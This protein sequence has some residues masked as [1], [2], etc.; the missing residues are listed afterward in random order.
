[1]ILELT[2]NT[3]MVT[4]MAMVMGMVMENT[5]KATIKSKINLFLKRYLIGK[6]KDKKAI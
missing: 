4:D 6:R 1:M 2:T 3:V 5:Q